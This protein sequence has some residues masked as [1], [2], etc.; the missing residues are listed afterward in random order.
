MERKLKPSPP[1]HAVTHA[2]GMGRI[3][4]P[5]RLDESRPTSHITRP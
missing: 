2:G 5:E 4:Q 1:S 3:C